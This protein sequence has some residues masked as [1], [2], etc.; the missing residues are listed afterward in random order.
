MDSKLKNCWIL[1]AVL[2]GLHVFV[3]C[4]YLAGSNTDLFWALSNF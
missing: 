4:A 1:L 3:F 2:A